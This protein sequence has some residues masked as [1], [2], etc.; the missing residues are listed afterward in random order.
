MFF[1]WL[2]GVEL[3]CFKQTPRFSCRSARVP[4]AFGG[5]CWQDSAAGRGAAGRAP[6]SRPQT[7]C[8][9]LIEKGSG[10]AWRPRGD[11]LLALAL[12]FGVAPCC[13]LG[14]VFPGH[15]VG[16]GHVEK[17]IAC[18]G[19][20]D[21]A[22]CW[23]HVGQTG[24]GERCAAPRR[25]RT[26][27]GWHGPAMALSRGAA[28]QRRAPGKSPAALGQRSLGAFGDSG[29]LLCPGSVSVV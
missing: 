16:W 25:A 21:S 24:R 14:K 29:A 8:K 10:E 3:G 18:D 7:P 15:R 4:G 27:L 6:S 11:P 13:G 23:E 2:Q 12:H 1:M 26:C 28:Q 20:E 17:G 19:A 22:C 9:G 5:G